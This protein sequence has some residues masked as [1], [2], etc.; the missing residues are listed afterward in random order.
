MEEK[1]AF[2]TASHCLILLYLICFKPATADQIN[3][4]AKAGDNVILPC[5]AAEN[6]PVQVAEWI[7]TDLQNPFVI[8]HR[9]NNQHDP[10]GQ[11]AAFKNRVDLLD[12]KS[13]DVSL[14]LKNVTTNDTGKYEC[15]VD[16]HSKNRRKRAELSSDPITIV[17]LT[18]EQ[19]NKDGQMKNGEKENGRKRPGLIVA[20][21]LF[22]VVL[23]AAVF[24][25]LE[26][27]RRCQSEQP[28][29]SLE[30][31]MSV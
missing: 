30:V 14:I 17:N 15:R 21:V 25:V 7:R 2:V 16:Y 3:I 12:V 28:N 29:T 31:E 10:E 24:A 5:R 4:T 20:V 22:A 26:C 19:G 8:L 11:Y 9:A 6:K 1:S 13:G 23:F 18:V 27:K